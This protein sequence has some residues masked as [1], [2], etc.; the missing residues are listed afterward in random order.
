MTTHKLKCWPVYFDAVARGEKTFEGRR[1][2]RGFQEGDH[3]VLMR[4][5]GGGEP[6]IVE[7]APVGSGREAM[8]ELHFEIGHVLH[9]GQ[10]GIQDGW[11]VF[12][13]L[14]L[15]WHLGR[16]APLGQTASVDV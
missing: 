13:L 15:G 10:F 16:H 9:G 3:V 4:T 11:C 5:Y 14:P 12:S 6:W 7:P 8:H 2:D 1:D